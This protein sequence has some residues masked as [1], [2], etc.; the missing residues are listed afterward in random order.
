MC[1]AFPVHV[2]LF[3]LTGSRN[4]PPPPFRLFALDARAPRM[5]V[6]VVI[7]GY[8]GEHRVE[9][10][11]VD[12]GGSTRAFGVSGGCEGPRVSGASVCAG[13]Q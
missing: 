8:W 7:H 10:V 12:A 3:D 6:D 4:E 1:P 11:E 9:G 2:G 13:A 5:R